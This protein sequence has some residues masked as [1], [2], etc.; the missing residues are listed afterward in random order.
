MNKN[1]FGPI[2]EDILIEDTEEKEEE[3]QSPKKN[4][5]KIPKIDLQKLLLSTPNFFLKSPKKKFTALALVLG[6]IIVIYTGLLLLSIKN[7]SQNKQESEP[8]QSPKTQ[9]QEEKTISEL[10]RKI[11]EYNIRLNNLDN[12]SQKLAQPIVNLDIGFEL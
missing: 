6:I 7:P 12:Y 5:A 1:E 2:E 3:S 8:E 10:A 9:T 4:A 11:E